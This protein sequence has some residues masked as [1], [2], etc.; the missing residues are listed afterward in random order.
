MAFQV[1]EFSEFHPLHDSS[2]NYIKLHLNLSGFCERSAPT[3]V[4]ASKKGCWSEACQQVW[5]GYNLPTKIIPTK[6]A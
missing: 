6:I 4:C 5:S 2:L 1:S 3:G